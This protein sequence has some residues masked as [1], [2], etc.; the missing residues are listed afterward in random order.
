MIV[1]E[2]GINVV[3]QREYS[4]GVSLFARLLTQNAAAARLASDISP[5]LRPKGSIPA[6]NISAFTILNFLTMLILKVS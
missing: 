1:S 5:S 3:K 6:K 4:L 2:S